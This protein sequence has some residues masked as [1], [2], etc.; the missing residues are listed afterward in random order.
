MA[1]ARSNESPMDWQW[2]KEGGPADPSSPYAQHNQRY[3]QRGFENGPA[4]KRHFGESVITPVKDRPVLAAPTSKPLFF[5]PHQNLLDSANWRTPRDIKSP[6]SEIDDSPAVN[7]AGIDSMMSLDDTPT[8]A[9]TTTVSK[10][11]TTDAKAENQDEKNKKK[12]GIFGSFGFS[13]AK[14]STRAEVSKHTKFSDKAAKKVAKRRQRHRSGTG[15]FWTNSGDSYDDDDDD[16]PFGPSRGAQSSVPDRTWAETHRDVP[17]ILS[18]YL[19]LF[20]NILIASLGIYFVYLIVGTI[21]RDVDK[22]VQEY[23]GEAQIQV[24]QCL[25]QWNINGCSPETRVPAMEEKCKVW[26]ICADGDP[27]AIGRSK[28][29]AETFAEIINGFVEP[30]SYKSMA[31]TFVLVFGCLFVSNFAF[32]FFRAKV[33]GHPAPVLAAAAPRFVEYGGAAGVVHP[34]GAIFATPARLKARG[35]SRSPTKAGRTPFFTAKKV[36]KREEEDEDD[37]YEEEA[38]PTVSRKQIEW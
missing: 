1:R 2:D 22:K 16:N 14:K 15:D 34:Y 29:S 17:Q 6:A 9:P 24:A 4:R 5:T 30:I 32:G 38:S 12:T 18:Q 11:T 10:I 35:R 13:P 20:V 23:V 28:V 7:V 31:F 26:R 25:H 36:V 3:I 27:Y 21:Q 19:Q 33:G 37:G 8:K